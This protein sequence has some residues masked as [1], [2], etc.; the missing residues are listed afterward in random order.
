MSRGREASVYHPDQM[1]R[2]RTALAPFMVL[3]V[4]ASAC[5]AGAS[6]SPSTTLT[7]STP[8]AVSTI[9]EAPDS[10]EAAE[11]AGDVSWTTTAA[12]FSGRNGDNVE[13][14]C[15]PDGAPYTV[16]GTELYTDDSSV[17][18]AAVHAGAITLERGGAVTIEIQPGSDSYDGSEDNGITTLDYAAWPGSFVIL[19]D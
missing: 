11:S 9:G 3:L 15:P 14:D 1:I 17:C 18:T 2:L 7:A 16:W 12:E 5:S 6:A 4:L 13:Y 19:T 8:V 10:G